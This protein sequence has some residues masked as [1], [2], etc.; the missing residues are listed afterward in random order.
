LL[1]AGAGA[2]AVLAMFRNLH[3]LK[4]PT[5]FVRWTGHEDLKLES[6]VQ[7]LA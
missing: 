3:L 4:N 7:A 6:I 1:E 5:G 2:V